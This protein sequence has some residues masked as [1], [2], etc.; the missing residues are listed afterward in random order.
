MIDFDRT[1]WGDPTADRTIR[2]TTAK[3]DGWQSFWETSGPLD[4]SDAA[5]WRSKIYEA[6]HLGAVRLERHRLGNR[7]GVRNSYEAIATLLAAVG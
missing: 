1:L 5:T 2:S 7:E 3:A 6:R 4:Q